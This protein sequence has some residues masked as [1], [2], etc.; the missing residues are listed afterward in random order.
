LQGRAEVTF[1]ANATIVL[2]AS[3]S[4]EAGAAQL[5]LDLRFEP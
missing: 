5:C 2:S 4:P 1:L 3:P